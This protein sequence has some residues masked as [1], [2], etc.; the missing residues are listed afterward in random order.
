MS[1]ASQ[2]AGRGDMSDVFS[3]PQQVASRLFDKPGGVPVRLELLNGD[4]ASA[5]YHPVAT[6]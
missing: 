4:D 1:A 6:R 5:G 2:L 3:L